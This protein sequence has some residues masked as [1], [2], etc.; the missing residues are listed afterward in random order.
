M[1]P[2]EFDYAAPESLSEALALLSQR[3]EDAKLLAGGHSLIPLMKLRLAAPGLLID[4]RRLG[5]LSGIRRDGDTLVIGA[6]TTH[7]EVAASPLLREAAPALSQA[8]ASIGDRQVRAR[9]TIG[10]SLA[11]ADPAADLPAVILAL[12]AELVARSSS[13]ER[14]IAAD[15]FFT[16]LLETALQPEEMLTEIRVPVAPR[17]AYLK[18]PNPASHYA[19]AGVAVALQG[20]GTISSARVGVTGATFYA[21]RAAAAERAL[22]GRPLSDDAI[23]EA[24]DQAV[25]ADRDFLSDIHASAEYRRQLVR[26]AARRALRGLA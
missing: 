6:T 22:Q 26:V 16:G 12:N 8:A 17:S 4:L 24:A 7:R 14:R 20:N 5:E 1:I 11:H 19:L 15:G 21:Y 10:G 13:G 2:N 9:G 25:D 3:P 18:M 23:T